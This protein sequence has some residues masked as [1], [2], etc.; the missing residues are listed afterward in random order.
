MNEFNRIG[1]QQCQARLLCHQSDDGDQPQAHGAPH[2]SAVQLR[3]FIGDYTDLAAGSDGVFHALWAD[4][5]AK[6]TVHWFFGTEFTAP[7]QPVI[8]QQDVAVFNGSF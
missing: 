4:T 8:N 3:R 6:Q 5:N 2:Q 1:P 7:N